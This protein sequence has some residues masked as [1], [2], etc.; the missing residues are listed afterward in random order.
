MDTATR[1]GRRGADKHGGAGYVIR[2]KQASGTR[3]KL[4][5]ILPPAVDISADIIGIIGFHCTGIHGVIVEHKI[6]KT[7]RKPLNLA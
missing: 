4:G 2:I 5:D 3:E 7:G 6:P 1:R